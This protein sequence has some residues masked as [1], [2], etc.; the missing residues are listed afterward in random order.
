L[1]NKL[2]V[3]AILVIK[4]TIYKLIYDLNIAKLVISECDSYNK[5][6]NLQV[7]LRKVYRNEMEYIAIFQNMQKIAIL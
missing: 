4:R 7:K 2:L 5:K 1:P 3:N 6:D